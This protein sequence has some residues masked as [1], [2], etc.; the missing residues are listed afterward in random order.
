MKDVGKAILVIDMQNDFVLPGAPL[1]VAGAMSTVP[2]ISEFLRF[3]RREGWL[4]IFVCRIHRASGID[5]ECFRRHLFDAGSGFCVEGSAGAAIV[6]GLRREP[7]DLVVAKTRFDA[8]FHTDLETV[9]RSAGIGELFITGTQYPNCVRS[10]AV[11]AMERDYKVT[12]VT[13]CCSAATPEIAEANIYDM[14][15]MGIPCVTSKEVIKSEY[16]GI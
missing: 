8:F 13:D 11:G 1:C 5:A 9:L 2:A 4:V 6:D 14:S 10:T 12:V 16:N 7:Q 15:K 3:G